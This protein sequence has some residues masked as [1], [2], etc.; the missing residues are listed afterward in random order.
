[1]VSDETQESVVGSCE[2]VL[3]L[4]KRFLEVFQEPSSLPSQGLMITRFH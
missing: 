4:L 2:G 3:E 1:M